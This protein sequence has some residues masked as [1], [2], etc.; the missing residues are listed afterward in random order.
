MVASLKHEHV[1]PQ[2]GQDMPDPLAEQRVIVRNNNLHC[3]SLVFMEMPNLAVGVSE[4][5]S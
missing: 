2:I 4:R 1:T 3:N 5:E